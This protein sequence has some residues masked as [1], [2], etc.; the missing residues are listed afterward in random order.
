MWLG[1][2]YLSGRFQVRSNIQWAPT[3]TAH[4]PNP[5]ITLEDAAGQQFTSGP[6][7]ATAVGVGA[8]QLQTRITLTGAAVGVAESS[9]TVIPSAFAVV[10]TGIAT[11]AT[12]SIFGFSAAAVATGVATSLTEF[13]QL[14]IYKKRRTAAFKSAKRR[15]KRRRERWF[16]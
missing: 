7:A 14:Y 8:I 16:W 15:R 2:R 12:A 5:P 13:L 11:S 4:D 6:H 9:R 1:Q 10:S 3:R